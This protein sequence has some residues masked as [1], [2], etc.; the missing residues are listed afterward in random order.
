MT[1]PTTTLPDLDALG[2]T[3][4]AGYRLAELDDTGDREAL[5]DIDRW[6]FADFTEPEDEAVWRWPL[7]PGRSVGIWDGR[8]D[9]PRLVAAHSSYAFTLPVPG[10]QR[11][12]TAGLTW[13]S[14][15]P[16]H[17]R[18]G[19]AR[20][21][22]VAH[23]HRSIARGEIVSALNA[24]EAGIYGRYG[25]GIATHHVHMTL[26]RRADLREVPGSDD[27][28]VELESADPDRHTT[29]LQEVHAAVDRPGWITRDTPVLRRRPLLD[30]PS[31]RRGAEALRIAVVCTAAGEP[32]GYAIFRRHSSWSAAHDPL[33][34]VKVR[35]A[36]ALDAAAARAL[37]GTLADLDLMS[38]VET[39]ELATDDA[40]RGLVVD[41]RAARAVEHD[42]VWLRLL[43][44]PAALS[45]RHYQAPV[46]VVLEVR[47]T[48]LPGNSGR[49]HLRGGPDV[50]TVV[51]ATRGAD[52][53]LDVADLAAVYLG[54]TSLGALALAGRARE[55]TPGTL[56]AA[57]AAFGWP[58]APAMSWGF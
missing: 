35:E 55:I 44:V 1:F 4:P 51:P 30:R 27:L 37:W 20:A 19:L 8:G 21:M 47:D 16:G 54:G 15:H 39:G 48:V 24:A 36:V 12:P 57:S 2:V 33:G 14:V 9:V 42:G 31:E 49:W 10:G 7:E 40:L 25:Y 52:V 23:L 13:V 43:D 28:V 26:P 41:H 34:V 50:A 17:R 45:A 29:L 58:V 38:S 46:D 22:V 32:R 18:R 56:A 3:L 6:A 5:L 11:V 53:A